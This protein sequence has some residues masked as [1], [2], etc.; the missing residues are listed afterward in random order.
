MSNE[1]ILEQP[2]ASSKPPSDFNDLHVLQGLSVVREQIESGISSQAS[3]F[4]PPPHP[5][6]NAGHFSGQG[7]E[8][9]Q[10]MPDSIIYDTAIPEYHLEMSPDLSKVHA[11]TFETGEQVP[12]GGG[13]LLTLSGLNLPL[14][15][16]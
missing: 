1:E 7:S 10:N 3:A 14:K 4:A 8:Y 6:S 13:R 15:S 11:S 2:Q 12:E 16:A 5:L 9:V